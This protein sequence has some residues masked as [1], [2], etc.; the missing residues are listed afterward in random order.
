MRNSLL[1]D[2]AEQA[3]LMHPNQQPLGTHLAHDSRAVGDALS[4][5]TQKQGQIYQER[6]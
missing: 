4:G 1:Y 5:L 2:T 6:K 3:N